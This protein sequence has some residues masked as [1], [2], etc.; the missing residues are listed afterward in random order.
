MTNI[1]RQ[2]RIGNLQIIRGDIILV[3]LDPVVG[4]EQGKTRPALIIQNDVGN[5]YSP[6]TIIAPITTKIYSQQYPTNVQISKKESKLK[7]ESTILFNQIRT[8]DKK[9]IVKKISTLDRFVLAKVDLA[10]KI[11][12]GL[13]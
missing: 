4:S 6:L 8:I 11:S 3:N 5:K 13:E 9:R 10:I 7:K 12:L 2:T 1:L